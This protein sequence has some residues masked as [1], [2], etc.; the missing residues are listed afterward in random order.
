MNTVWNFEKAIELAPDAFIVVNDKGIIVFVNAQTEVIF[1]YERNEM[2]GQPVEMLMPE[3]SAQK[4]ASHR[5]NFFS[6]PHKRPMGNGLA[7][8]GKKKNNAEFPVEISLS[9]IESGY[10]AAIIRDVTERFLNEYLTNKTKQLE[11]FAYIT[12]HNLRSPVSNL[13]SLTQFYKAENTEHGKQLLFDKVDQTV[14]KLS[15]TLNALMDILIINQSQQQKL[16][17]VSFNE[18][19]EKVKVSLESLI[20][21][22]NATIVVDFSAAPTI[23]YSRLYLESIIQNL[24][25]NSL[26]YCDENRALTIH[27]KTFIR[28][29][30]IIFEITDNGLGIDLLR[31]GDKIFGLNK[32]F[33]NHPDA[34]GV[35]LFITKAQVESMGGQIQVNSK[36]N[37]GTTFTVIF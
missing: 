29:E 31:H 6:S 18:T 10:V 17:D 16:V 34:R 20:E 3:R 32:V 24:L 15:E 11:D 9:P 1:G 37:E 27:L 13:I 8:F 14:Q 2:L 36:E 35:G 22:A 33:H 30:K 23:P 7:L 19:L 21:Q 4:H 5:D 12:S 25:S 26:K 28:N